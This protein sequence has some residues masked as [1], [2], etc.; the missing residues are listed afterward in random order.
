MKRH[1]ID[2]LV[3]FDTNIYNHLLKDS[4][5]LQEIKNAVSKRTIGIFL[6]ITNLEELLGGLKNDQSNTQDIQNIFKLTREICLSGRVTQALFELINAEFN[7]L[8][9]STVRINIYSNNKNVKEKFLY[10]WELLAKNPNIKNEEIIK[11]ND[12]IKRDKYGFRDAMKIAKQKMQE[13]IKKDNIPTEATSEF[14]DNVINKSNYTDN[15]IASILEDKIKNS[16]ITVTMVK[17]NLPA[18]KGLYHWLYY[19]LLGIIYHHDFAGGEPEPGDARDMHHAIY[20]GYSD[21]F[22]SDDTNLIKYLRYIP[23]NKHQYL[24]LDE[25]IQYLKTLKNTI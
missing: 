12:E 17:K 6:S 13:A 3:Y 22:V 5:S 1:P 15:F 11:I 25:F 19:N 24:N 16:Q 4:I 18:M 10:W 7:H 14:I 8:V 21:I 23:T 9:D 20:A 2:K